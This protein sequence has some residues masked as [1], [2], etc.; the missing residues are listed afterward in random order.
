MSQSNFPKQENI[1]QYTAS[2]EVETI[3]SSE[4]PLPIFCK[5]ALLFPPP[6]PQCFLTSFRLKPSMAHSKATTF[7]QVTNYSFQEPFG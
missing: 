1:K 2:I 5:R 7:N 6:P 3:N 4:T